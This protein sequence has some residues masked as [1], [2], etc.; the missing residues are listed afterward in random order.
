MTNGRFSG[1]DLAEGIF[2]LLLLFSGIL[3]T[4]YASRTK[5]NITNNQ[6]S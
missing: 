5:A 2:S 4:I 3:G 1:G 6:N